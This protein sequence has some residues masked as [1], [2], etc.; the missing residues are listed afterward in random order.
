MNLDASSIVPN[1]VNEKLYLGGK[2]DFILCA[3]TDPNEGLVVP[4]GVSTWGEKSVLSV[5]ASREMCQRWCE[6]EQ[7]IWNKIKG[8]DFCAGAKSFHSVLQEKEQGSLLNVKIGQK[9]VFYK[10]DEKTGQIS[11]IKMEQI[12]PQSKIA[13]SIKLGSPWV[14]KIGNV[15]KCG[16]TVYA[17][18]VFLL[19]A[20]KAKKERGNT[21]MD[22]MKSNKKR[23]QMESYD[24]ED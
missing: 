8:E 12:L 22:F 7:E 13:M 10:R 1:Y 4:F 23:K 21:L 19:S 3:T 18:N 2:T 20:G 15:L 14:Y 17:D 5:K 24:E 6:F 11:K 9:T 16:I